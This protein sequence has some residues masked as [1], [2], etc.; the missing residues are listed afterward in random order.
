MADQL[1]GSSA[2]GHE[3]SAEEEEYMRGRDN[4]CL[5]VVPWVPSQ[6]PPASAT[7]VSQTDAPEP[8]EEAE[9]V[10]AAMDIEETESAS[11]EQ[12]HTSVHDVYSGIAGSDGLHQWQQQ[13]CM[14]PQI[15][16]NTSTPITWFR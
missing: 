9:E 8:M 13:H 10:E 6:L 4:G 5:A 16:Q 2:Y 7:E 14:I 12:G 11:I 3:K 1:R 15:P